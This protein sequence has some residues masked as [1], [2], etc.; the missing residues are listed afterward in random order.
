[1]VCD[2]DFRDGGHA[3]GIGAEFLEESD[4]GGGFVFGAVACAVD[5]F[6][7]KE[8]LFFGGLSDDVAQLSVIRLAHVGESGTELI[9]VEPDEWAS[10]HHHVEV[11][12]DEHEFAG[13]EVWVGSAG[14]VGDDHAGTAETMQ[15]ADGECDA[16]EVSAFIIVDA[17]LHDD[18]VF[19]VELAED[20]VS[21]MSMHAGGWESFDFAVGDDH[22]I[23]QGIDKRAESG[24]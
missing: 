19:A 15:N 7:Q 22:G 6:A 16:F 5:A 4:F 17:S 11:V 1:M 2:D 23:F 9:F 13:V 20:Q 14:G 3:D 8:A 24:A 10:G 12:G 18:E 21:G